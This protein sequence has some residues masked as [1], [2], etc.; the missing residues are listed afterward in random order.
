MPKQQ[1]TIIKTSKEKLKSFVRLL[2][3]KKIIHKGRHLFIIHR[4]GGEELKKKENNLGFFGIG[5]N[6]TPPHTP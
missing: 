2:R 3:K 1:A 5:T 4:S 6:P